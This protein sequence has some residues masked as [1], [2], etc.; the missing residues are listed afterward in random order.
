MRI[1]IYTDSEGKKKCYTSLKRMFDFNTNLFLIKSKIEY[2]FYR[3]KR[4][5]KK[6][7]ILIERTE[8]I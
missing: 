5:Y 6:D 7:D 8:L 1:I 2:S 3:K 4:D